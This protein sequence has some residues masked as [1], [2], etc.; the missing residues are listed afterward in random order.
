MIDV[1]DKVLFVPGKDHAFDIDS[2]GFC[3]WHF[4][5]EDKRSKELRDVV[6]YEVRTLLKNKSRGIRTPDLVPVRPRCY[7]PATVVQI[8]EDNTAVLA[9][10]YPLPGVTHHYKDVPYS[11]NK[12]PHTWHTA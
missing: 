10:K 12:D 5:I 3:A 7:W 6:P 1:G 8:N 9:I 11:A 2:D 4:A